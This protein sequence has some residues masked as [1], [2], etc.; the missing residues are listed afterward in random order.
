MHLVTHIQGIPHKMVLVVN[1]LSI[2]EIIFF[3]F[4][5]AKF[6]LVHDVEATHGLC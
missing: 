1:F 4:V 5:V 2:F 3:S 6:D